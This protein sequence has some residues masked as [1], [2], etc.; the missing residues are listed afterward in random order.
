MSLSLTNH[1]GVVTARTKEVFPGSLE[2]LVFVHQVHLPTWEVQLEC[3]YDISEETK[4]QFG[5]IKTAYRL[6]GTRSHRIF[7]PK[8]DQRHHQATNCWSTVSCSLEPSQET[9]DP[10]V[11]HYLWPTYVKY[12]HRKPKRSQGRCLYY[13]NT[14]ASQQLLLRGGD[15]ST[16]PGPSKK[17]A[18]KCE[19]CE[20]KNQKKSKSCWLRCMPW[21]KSCEMRWCKK[22]VSEY[23]LDLFG[24]FTFCSLFP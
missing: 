16:N 1:C 5:T 24:L 18:T 23:G 21:I 15:I 4:A 13:P 20:K 19:Q 14:C 9:F 8:A 10:Q 6:Q 2:A 7:K 3:G 11:T 22:C 12:I 17:A